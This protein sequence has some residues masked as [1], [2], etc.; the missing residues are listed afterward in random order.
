[1]SFNGFPKLSASLHQIH[2]GM[3]VL[4]YAPE[5]RPNLSNMIRSAEFF[6]LKQVYLY[7]QND[8]LKPPNNKVSRADMEHLARVWTAGAIEFVEIIKVEQ[9]AAFLAQYD[10]RKIATVVD[11]TAQ[12]LSTFSFQSNDLLLMGSE[13]NGLPA[14]VIDLCDA[15]IYLPALGNTDCLNVSVSFGIFL[16][17]GLRQLAERG[18]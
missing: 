13:K 10:G 12:L 2:R 16:H 4:F 11:P 9:P 1:M 18:K 5:Y 8:L 14:E 17:E 15:A 7:D 6:G 3:Q